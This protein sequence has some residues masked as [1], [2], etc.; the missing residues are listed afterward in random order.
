MVKVSCFSWVWRKDSKS[1]VQTTC[2]STSNDLAGA[3]SGGIRSTF[4]ACATSR[5]SDAW[6]P[7]D[8]ENDG[9]VTAG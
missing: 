1:E 6:S 2:A 9:T 4:T 5:C 3:D 7:Q 8:A